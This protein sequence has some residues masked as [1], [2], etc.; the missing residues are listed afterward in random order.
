[1]KTAMIKS[2]LVAA[3]ALSPLALSQTACSSDDAFEKQAESD[4]RVEAKKAVVDVKKCESKDI[5]QGDQLPGTKPVFTPPGIFQNNGKPMPVDKTEQGNAGLL[6]DAGSLKC[7]HGTPGGTGQPLPTDDQLGKLKL[8]I[9]DSVCSAAATGANGCS[10]LAQECTVTGGGDPSKGQVIACTGTVWV[11]P[12]EEYC[13]GQWVDCSGKPIGP[14]DRG[15]LKLTEGTGSPK[16]GF[17]SKCPS[18]PTGD[19]DAEPPTPQPVDPVSVDMKGL[20]AAR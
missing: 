19:C 17:E 5:T 4:Q 3:F 9:I 15:G 18:C 11:K 8:P 7:L 14:G 2:V 1:M 20:A 16:G 12:G 6:G 13:E 10:V